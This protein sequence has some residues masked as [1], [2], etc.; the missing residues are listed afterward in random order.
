MRISLD[1]CID[2]ISIIEIINTKIKS[3]LREVATLDLLLIIYK[4]LFPD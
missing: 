4:K 1:C 2:F 3:C